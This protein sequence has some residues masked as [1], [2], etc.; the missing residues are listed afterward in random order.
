MYAP[1]ERDA[2]VMGCYDWARTLFNNTLR[3]N[4]IAYKPRPE[5][6]AFY[7]Y[8]MYFFYLGELMMVHP[9]SDKSER[10]KD[11]FE[12]GWIKSRIAFADSIDPSL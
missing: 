8:H 10:A 7:C 5:R 1:L 6:L 11:Y 3:E 4:G 9:I 12:D 2:W